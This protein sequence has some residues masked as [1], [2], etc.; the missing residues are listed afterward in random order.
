MVLPMCK[1]IFIML[2]L[3]LSNAYSVFAQNASD[4][5]PL[6]PG[7]KWFYKTVPYDSLN[8]AVDSLSTVRVDSFT[9]NQPYNNKSANII[10]SKHGSKESVLNKSYS[11]TNYVSLESTD[12]WT[13]M[14]SFPGTDTL[15]IGLFNS[16]HGWY[17]AYRLSKPTTTSYTIYSKDTLVNYS[18]I[19]TTLTHVVSAKRLPDQT[20]STALGDLLCKKFILNFLIKAKVSIISFSVLSIYDTVYIAPGNYIVSDIR[21]SADVDLSFFGQKA[22]YIAGCKMDIQTSIPVLSVSYENEIPNQ[23][24]MFQNYP[25]PFNPSTLIKYSLPF[26]SNI[27]IIVFNSIGQVVKELMSGVQ[28]S[29]MHELIFSSSTLP[30]G[31]YFYSILANSTDG[32]QS[33]CNTKKM[34]LLK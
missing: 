26:E 29:G 17:S 15:T 6:A 24:T 7:F 9:V 3:L 8:S 11:D 23:Y 25:N 22:F 18:G 33:F 10:I 5:F 27:R 2:I 31:I 13:F 30:S 16:F 4:Y 1:N 12:I 28:H 21:P 34:I 20:I 14:N 32:K 19:N